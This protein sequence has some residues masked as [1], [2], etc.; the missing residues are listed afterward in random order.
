MYPLVES[1]RLTRFFRSIRD[2]CRDS[3]A[4][5]NGSIQNPVVMLNQ[6]SPIIFPSQYCMYRRRARRFWF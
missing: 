2:V 1:F 4:Q 5:I 3:G 6:S